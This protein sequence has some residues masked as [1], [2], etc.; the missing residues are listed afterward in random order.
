MKK[1]S[2]AA[3]LAVSGLFSMGAS[4]AD[5]MIGTDVLALAG[6]LMNVSYEGSLNENAAWNASF[7]TGTFYTATAT[8]IGGHYKGYLNLDGVDTGKG[9]VYW[10]AGANYISVSASSGTTTLSGSMILPSL[11]AGYQMDFTPE[12]TGGA[13]L[14]YAGL[15]SGISL[16]VGYKL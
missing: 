5:N 11:G 16:W 6:G 15:A 13:E 9:Q 1:I 10:K 7:A 3:L 2:K 14:G 12:V 8:V 4:A